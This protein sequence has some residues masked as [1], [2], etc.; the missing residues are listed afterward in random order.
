MDGLDGC[1]KDS[2]TLR[3]RRTLAQHGHK[4]L[5]FRHPSNR[6]FGRMSKGAL[7][8]SGAVAIAVT[9]VFY[10]LDVLASVRQYN[11]ANDGVIIFVRYLLGTAYLPPRL[12]RLAYSFFRR[13]LPFPDTPLFIDIEPSVAIRRIE[14]RNQAREMFET[15]ERL[16]RIR[17]VAHSIAAGEWIVV[18]NSEEGERPFEAVQDILQSRG[19]LGRTLDT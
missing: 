7:Q 4:V 18:E 12:A 16:R 15:E 3:I 14:A 8:R 2:H 10:T 5:L 17:H 13:I 1:G 11:R 19:L 6:I 9:T